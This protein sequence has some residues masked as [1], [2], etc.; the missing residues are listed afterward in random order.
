MRNRII[1]GA[2]VIAQR[3]TSAVA[4]GFMV[5]RF[6]AFENT[7]G[8]FSWQQVAVAPAGFNF[9][10]RCTV[11]TANA[12]PSSSDVANFQH[13]IEGLNVADLGWGT[14]NAKTVTLS[15]WIR[16]SLTGNFGA[17]IL[18]S[19]VNRSYP[20]LYSISAANTWEYK[21]VT[22]PGDTSGTWLTDNGIGLR[23]MFNI[24]GGSTVLGT[25][26][27]WAGSRFDGATGSTNI[28]ATLNATWQITGV[29]LEVGTQATSFEYR[30]YQQELAL[31]Q[32]YYVGLKTYWFT[33]G[34]DLNYTSYNSGGLPWDYQMRSSPSV[35]IG[36]GGMT[37]HHGIAPSA[38][39]SSANGVHLQ[40]S[41]SGLRTNVSCAAYV[42]LTLSAE[43]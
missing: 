24:G 43:L 40:F 42:D 1:N 35:I 16:S 3:G 19:G 4:D 41:G 9:S 31:A 21:T 26:N 23:I 25:A 30:Q 7:A 15:F 32:R 29:Q 2:M 10:A 17:S 33:V 5:D 14:A 27:T 20:F 8:V 39:S 34:Y 13:I 11:T 18:N 22:I 28:L 12:S 6:Q 36:G 38:I 37:G